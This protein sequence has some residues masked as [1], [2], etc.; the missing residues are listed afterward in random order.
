MAG[1][2][3]FER[4]EDYFANNHVERLNEQNGVITARVQGTQP[5]RVK[6]WL[7]KKDLDYSCNCPVGADGEFC[8]HCVAVGLSWLEGNQRNVPSGK[9]DRTAIVTTDDV[10]DY[11]KGQDKDA[12]VELLVDHAAQDER[13]GQRLFLKTARKTS[14]GLNL[15][16]YRHA[17]DEAVEPDGFAKDTGIDGSAWARE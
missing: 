6:L 12:L 10:R 7:D 5:Y 14:K 2:V 16:T 8:K 17:I 11:L 13:L 1:A 15:A 4:G 9:A 3:S